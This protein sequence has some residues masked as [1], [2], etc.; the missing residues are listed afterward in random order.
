MWPVEYFAELA[1]KIYAHNRNIKLIV[2]GSPAENKLCHSFQSLCPGSFVINECG[3]W[4]IETLPDLISSLDLLI[5]NDTGTMHL[6]IALGTPTISLFSPTSAKVFGPLQDLDIHA[7][8]QEQPLEEG[9]P[10]KRRSNAGMKQISVQMVFN[11]VCVFLEERP[12]D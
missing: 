3:Q 9:M 1:S 2:T 4:T 8:F 7:V 10:K 6:A 11:Q 5:T 12:S